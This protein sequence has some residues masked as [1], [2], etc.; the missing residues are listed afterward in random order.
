MSKYGFALFIIFV[1]Y[2][3]C[4]GSDILFQHIIDMY[5]RDREKSMGLLLLPKIKLEHIQLT[6]FSRMLLRYFSQ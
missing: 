2:I 3:E 1:S 5:Y 6:P 4:D